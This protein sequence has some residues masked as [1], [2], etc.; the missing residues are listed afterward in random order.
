MGCFR[1]DIEDT[2]DTG[3]FQRVG[4]RL[5]VAAKHA[6]SAVAVAAEFA[7]AKANENQLNLLLETRRFVDIIHGESSAAEETDASKFVEVSHGD[8]LG[9]HSA[10]GETCHSAMGLISESTEVGINVRNQFVDENRLKWFDLEISETAHLNI[11]CHA[12]GHH[13]NERFDFAF[14][15]QV[16]HDQIGMTLVTPGCFILTPAMLQ[17]ENRIAFL[18]ILVVLGGV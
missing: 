8:C 14:G 17:V 18:F 11:V 12:I 5:W 1:G 13:N 7:A 16:V 2:V 9:F 4:V 10:H 15:D 6:W 3:L